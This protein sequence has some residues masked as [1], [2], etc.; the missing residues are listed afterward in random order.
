M[1]KILVADE[2]KQVRDMLCISLDSR[3]YE[4]IEA[5]NGDDALTII[6]TLRPAV[7]ILQADLP[8]ISGL[9]LCQQLSLAGGPPAVLLVSRGNEN[10]GIEGLNLGAD[11][12]L[13]IPA[14]TK[15]TL[16]RIEALM[17]RCY[18]LKEYRPEG[19]LQL[20]DLTIDIES[21]YAQA[22]GR[23]ICLTSREL[24]L[25]WLLAKNPQKTFSREEIF[26]F[27]WL[28][29]INGNLRTV[30]THVKSIRRKLNI[31]S[32]SNWDIVTIWGVGYRFEYKYNR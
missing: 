5:D 11:D 18:K 31:P 27:L 9:Q 24:E 29:P 17:R 10:L 25:L 20:E 22:F 21:N 12:F 4:V 19:K 13:V 7:A 1:Y 3:E 26:R 28:K 14:S 8:G 23:D 6:S 16:A 15:E 30:D 2:K 32:D